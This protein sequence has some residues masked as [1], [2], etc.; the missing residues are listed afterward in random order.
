MKLEN[1]DKL[2]SVDPS[3]GCHLWTGFACKA[4]YGRFRMPGS[5]GKSAPVKLA[6]RYAYERAY[7]PIPHGM[8]V[9]H[10]CDT[11]RCVN[12][13]HLFLGTQKDNLRDMREK[14]RSRGFD[15]PGGFR[16][17]KQA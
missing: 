1:F 5:K 9:C 4:G 2:V 15:A 3:T 7:G 11:P 12:P 6:H 17:I 10:R 16:W 14:G 8:N 13:D